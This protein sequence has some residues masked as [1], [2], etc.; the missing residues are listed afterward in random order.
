MKTD[1][2]HHF[3]YE[4]LKSHNEEKLLEK[5]MKPKFNVHYSFLRKTR[6]PRGIK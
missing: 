5:K 2:H 3:H 1:S 4:N 6:S